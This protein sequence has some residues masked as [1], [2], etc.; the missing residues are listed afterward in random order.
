[1]IYCFLLL[2]CFRSWKY[3]SPFIWMES[4]QRWRKFRGRTKSLFWGL[5]YSL[6]YPAFPSTAVFECETPPL[7]QVCTSEVSTSCSSLFSNC[8]PENASV[9]EEG[10]SLADAFP[11]CTTILWQ[12]GG[13]ALLCLEY[14]RCILQIF[15]VKLLRKTAQCTG[16]TNRNNTFFLQTG[17]QLL[18]FIFH[19]HVRYSTIV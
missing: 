13:E 7:S 12:Q 19:S 17:H 18:F 9:L 14:I 3:H 4:T 2:S 15:L 10:C 5:K 8:V 16:S 1:M 6:L 11:L